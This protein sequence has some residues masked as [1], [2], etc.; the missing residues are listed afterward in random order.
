MLERSD[1]VQSVHLT[2]WG[3]TTW[4]R[5][6]VAALKVA[7]LTPPP[8]LPLLAIAFIHA[9]AVLATRLFG[10][11]GIG[12]TTFVRLAFAALILL[13]LSR[14]RV[15]GLGR[16]TLGWTV[17]FG[18]ILTGL[19]LCFYEAVARLPLGVVATIEFLGPLSVALFASR[20]TRD[21][22]WVVLAAAGVVLLAP[23]GDLTLDPLGLGFALAASV[24][25]GAY[26]LVGSRVGRALPGVQGLALA[27][28]V[29]TLLSAPY[30]ILSAGASL[31]RPELLLLGFVVA[32]ISVVVPFS[33][34]Y[35]AMRRMSARAFGVLLSS[36]PA[37]AALIGVALLGDVLGGRQ[38]VALMCVSA[39]SAGSTLVGE[40]DP[41]A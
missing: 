12:G 18:I 31:L 30:G 5:A 3:H 16:S 41:E 29:A 19:S 28:G 25:L 33:L 22:L 1:R 7:E 38:V 21:V 17:L 6:R 9:G 40:N 23:L 35:V 2:R 13:A 27:L 39:A 32:L 11:L 24:C 37:I 4:E 15:R 34:E 14:P 26:I 8:V 10:S 20:R 36:E